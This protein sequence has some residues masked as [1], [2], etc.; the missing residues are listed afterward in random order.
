[1]SLTIFLSFLKKEETLENENDNNNPILC[2]TS[3]DS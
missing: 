3:V 2:L 1:M